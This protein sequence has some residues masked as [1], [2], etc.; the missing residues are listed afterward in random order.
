[1]PFILILVSFYQV[2]GAASGDGF[3]QGQV[4][5]NS[6]QLDQLTTQNQIMRITAL[7]IHFKSIGFFL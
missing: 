3:L 6:K 4:F 1:M 2:Y 7:Q 5:V